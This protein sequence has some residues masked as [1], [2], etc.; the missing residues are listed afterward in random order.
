MINGDLLVQ[1]R[2][3]RLKGGRTHIISNRLWGSSIKKIKG[4]ILL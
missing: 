2:E 3:R 1:E 4:K